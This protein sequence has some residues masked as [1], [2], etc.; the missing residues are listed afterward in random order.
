M[1]RVVFFEQSIQSLCRL[2]A[3]GDKARLVVVQGEPCCCQ[4]VLESPEG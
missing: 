1:L 4:V 2:L 3:A